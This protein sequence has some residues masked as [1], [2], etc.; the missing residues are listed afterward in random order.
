MSND[1]TSLRDETD[2]FYLPNQCIRHLELLESKFRFDPVKELLSSSLQPLIFYPHLFLETL[3]IHNK[4]KSA[5]NT[6]I[7]VVETRFMH[8]TFWRRTFFFKF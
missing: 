6:S 2:W 7:K 3:L 5:Y 8:L 4:I 1:Q